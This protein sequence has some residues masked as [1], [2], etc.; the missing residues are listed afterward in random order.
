MK[1]LKLITISIDGSKTM[2]QLPSEMVKDIVQ[3]KH[4]T[5]TLPCYNYLDYNNLKRNN[6]I[7]TSRCQCQSVQL[8][9]KKMINHNEK[10]LDHLKREDIFLYLDHLYDYLGMIGVQLDEWN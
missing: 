6:V 10:C 3:M 4:E 5:K 9:L 8:K 7:S 1:V 2:I